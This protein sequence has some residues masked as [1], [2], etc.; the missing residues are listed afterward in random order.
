MSYS[1]DCPRSR[2]EQ[3]FLDGALNPLQAFLTRERVEGWALDCGHQWR[4]CVLSPLPTLLACIYKQLSPSVSC[5]DVEDWVAGLLPV[6][7]QSSVHGDDFCEARKRLAEPVF[8]RAVRHIASLVADPSIQRVWL[9]DGTGVS[10]PRTQDNFAAFGKA[11]GKARL[12]AAHL[13]LFSDAFGGAIT[14]ADITGCHEGELRQFLRCL[15]EVQPGTLLVA[16]RQFCSYLA[17]HEM[18]QRGISAVLRLN[19]SRKPVSVEVLGKNDEIQMW[20]RTPPGV[21]AFEER[22]Q[23]LPRFM[24]VRVVRA[25][26]V[27]KGY[28]PVTIALAT[29]L[30]D[31]EQ[32]PPGRIIE[33]YALRWRVENDIRDL[34]LRHGLAMLTCKS[35]ATVRREIWSAL[36]AYNA[37][38]LMQAQTGRSPRELSHERSRAIIVEISGQMAQALTTCL[39]ALNQ[40]LLHRL[41]RTGLKRQERP[42]CPRALVRST[43]NQYPFLCRTRQQWY[44][45]YLAA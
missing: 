27:R 30:L 1:I 18:T 43:S 44:A 35:E 24:R 20:R 39:P 41:A 32:W 40:R 5:R 26:I 19:V 37:V 13:L 23:Q 22:M 6:T 34:K 8:S 36:L 31:P 29:N 4:T 38:K 14:Q 12:P 10:L 42:P 9:V 15:P 3:F 16:D 45:H 17:L 7:L 2:L 11:H 33:M 21:S 28:R 25:Q